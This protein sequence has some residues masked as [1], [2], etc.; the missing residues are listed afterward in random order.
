[1]EKLR[2]IL[3]SVNDLQKDFIGVFLDPEFF[4]R[5]TLFLIYVLLLFYIMYGTGRILAKLFFEK[6][7]DSRLSHF[8][9]FALGYSFISILIFIVGLIGLLTELNMILLVGVLTIVSIWSF[10]RWPVK[11]QLTIDKNRNWIKILSFVFITIAF[12]RLV[13][14]QT[15]G[16]PLDYHLRFPRIYLENHTLMIPALGD[17]SY[18]TVPHLPELFYILTQVVSNGLMTHVVHFGFF[19]LIFFL[20]YRVNLLDKN[21]N[22]KSALA[23]LMF[24]SAP[25]MIQLG[26]QA[27]SDF[28]ALYCFS[29][30]VVLLLTSKIQKTNI[31]LSGVLLGVALA[32]KI[33]ILFY[34]PF[35][36]LFL[37]LLLKNNKL[38]DKAKKTLLF[39]LSSLIIV[40][41]WYIRAII[42]VGNPLY[43]N[44]S[45]GQNT[46]TYSHTEMFMKNFTLAGFSEKFNFT[47][48]YG[49]F[50]VIGLLLLFFVK[51]KE[52]FKYKKF[53]L[54]LILLMLPVLFFPLG[55]GRGRY[56]LP[57]MLLTYQLAA[58]GLIYFIKNYL[59][60][61]GLIILFAC[62]ALYYLF[63][64]LVILPYGLG[65]ANKDNFLRKNL[66]KDPASY[67]DFNGQFTRNIKKYETVTNYG[68]YELYYADFK[69]KNVFYFINQET[70]IFKLP[71]NI[72]KLLV[73]GGDFDWLC[74]HLG[75][76]N[77]KDY[78]VTL[79]TSDL[80]TKQYLYNIKYGRRN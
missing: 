9:N 47:L 33:W 63:N 26:T 78:T 53:F 80:R 38:M 20:L 60:K 79:I 77:C 12:L 43:I 51:R 74:K 25:L 22:K 23:A 24:V 58:V 67:Y 44:T 39:G 54:L 50:I 66:A 7:Y 11:F 27:F 41:P 15:A 10:K 5:Q 2:L 76:T 34:Y 1:M 72:S 36:V 46:Q 56:S 49:F 4:L 37:I 21:D 52:I 16:D 48:E 59:F 70:H 13:P 45:Q 42:L 71:S 29:L 28:P 30:S 8:I 65:W 32:S 62:L 73:R 68:V 14:P 55:F 6:N 75:I 64:T 69:Y 61:I 31:I 3:E 35:A 19:I 18:T 17:E 57:Y 40:L